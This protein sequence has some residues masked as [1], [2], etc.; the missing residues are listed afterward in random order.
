M[1]RQRLYYPASQI[2][3][4]LYTAGKEYMTI[5]NIEYIGFYHS[6][7]D[8]TVMTGAVYDSVESKVLKLYVDTVTQPESILYTDSISKGA[9]SR[10]NVLY[11]TQ[12]VFTYVQPQ[13]KDFI[14]G[15][16]KRYFIKRR[17]YQSIN[18][19]FEI[20]HTQYKLWKQI[21]SGIDESLY[22]AISIDWLLVGPLQDVIENSIVI[23]PGVTTTN[24]RI[25]RNASVN[26]IGLDTYVTDFIEFSTYS[27]LCP[28]EFKRK[29][30]YLTN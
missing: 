29:F 7:I 14:N 8:G 30:G 5:D 3:R 17:N 28:A 9:N 27:R 12:P 19:I 22:D 16:F 20:D 21:K 1:I 2:V 4:N 15:K 11:T 25:T 6:Y 23:R 10:T 13:E 18:D 26:F 24:E